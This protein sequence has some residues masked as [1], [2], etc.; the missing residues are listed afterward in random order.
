MASGAALGILEM[1]LAMPQARDTSVPAELCQLRRLQHPP[2]H[3]HA[4][5]LG[6]GHSLSYFL[7]EV[8]RE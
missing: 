7:P 8:Q 6:R 2:G 3:L 5:G 1:A 4:A